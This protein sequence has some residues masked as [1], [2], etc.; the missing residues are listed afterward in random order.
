MALLAGHFVDRALWSVVQET[1]IGVGTVDI[2][3]AIEAG[4]RVVGGGMTRR[5]YVALLTELLNRLLEKIRESRPMGNMAVHAAT[6]DKAEIA[7]G[8]VFIHERAVHF[9]MAFIAGVVGSS[10]FQ[11]V[12]EIGKQLVA[13]DT[14]D[15]AC[16]DRM[17]TEQAEIVKL[18]EV[19]VRAGFDNVF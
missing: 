16:L 19:A 11:R 6:I 18:L 15:R 17:R 13:I 12:A 1:A 9:R 5:Q 7:G 4:G 2:D 8:F 10:G 3:V 14:G